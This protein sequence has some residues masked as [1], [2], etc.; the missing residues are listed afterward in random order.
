MPS[1]LR[2]ALASFIHIYKQNLLELFQKHDTKGL[3]SKK[4]MDEVKSNMI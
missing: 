1:L 2:F 4:F 3:D